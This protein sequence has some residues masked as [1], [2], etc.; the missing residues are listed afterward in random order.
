MED[1]NKLYKMVKIV[2]KI[3]YDIFLDILQL[4]GSTLSERFKEKL[5]SSNKEELIKFKKK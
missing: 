2:K 1:I 4:G 3:D 5:L